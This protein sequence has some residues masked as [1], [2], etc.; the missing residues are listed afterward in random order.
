M[1]TLDA[2]HWPD[3]LATKPDLAE[4]KA[5]ILKWMFGAIGFQTLAILGG[6]AILLR[7]AGD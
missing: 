2:K 7:L 1:T 4:T 6:V 5:E 3:G